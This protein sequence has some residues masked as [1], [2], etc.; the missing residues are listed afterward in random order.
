MARISFGA[1]P[2]REKNLDSSRLDVVE[3]ARVPDM[4]RSLFPSGRVKDLSAPRYFICTWIS[5]IFSNDVYNLIYTRGADKSL[6]RPGGKKA[7]VSV[8]AWISFGALPC[9]KKK[10]WQ[11]AARCCWNRARPWHASEVGSFVVG[12]R[13]YQHS[14]TC[15]HAISVSADTNNEDEFISYSGMWNQFW[16]LLVYRH[17]EQQ[18]GIL[19]YTECLR[20]KAFAAAFLLHGKKSLHVF[21]LQLSARF[22]RNFVQTLGH[23]NSVQLI[24][25]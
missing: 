21:P 11:L 19:L 10:T 6:A 1:L 17:E 18:P 22:S 15:C 2:C 12:R 13:T 4:P 9:R 16:N 5:I 25:K 24:N 3:I 14:G 8:M 7:T 23:R 20:G